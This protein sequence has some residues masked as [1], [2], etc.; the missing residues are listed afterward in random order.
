M[1]EKIR[2]GEYNENLK[3]FYGDAK[4]EAAK[5]RYIGAIESFSALYGI[6]DV[7]IVS[8][9]GRSEVLGNHTDHNRGCVLAAAVNLDLI[10]VVSKSLAGDAGSRI[11]IKSEGFE[12]DDIDTRDL[13]ARGSEKFASAAIIRGICGRF[14]ELGHRFGGFDAYTTSDV[15]PGSGLSSSAA[16]E[17]A[18]GF[19]LN[20]LYNGGQISGLEIAQIGQYAENAYFGKPCGLMD[21]T[22]CSVGGFVSIDFRESAAPAFEKLDFDLS[23]SGYSLC[24]VSTGGSH[25]NLN[26]EYAAMPSEMK[27]IAGHFGK[28]VLRE[29]EKPAFSANIGKLRELCGDRAVL[30]AMHYF[31]ENARV[32]AGAEAL[33][34]GDFEGFLQLVAS[35]GNSSYKY[36]QNVY[37]PKTPKE[38]GLSLALALS[39]EMLAGR[40]AAARVHG[41]GF[42][43]T[44]QAFVP[45]KYVGEY[46]KKIGG[47][48]GEGSC[49]ELSVRNEGAAVVM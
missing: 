6:R 1:A 21:Q 33:K 15:L 49:L 7:E 32:R 36:L 26:D 37:D 19:I 4:T 12:A 24:I 46:F 41:G 25:H 47:V 27:Q 38:Q 40:Q 31:A 17:V 10:A 11:R 8:V 42:A 29:V 3:R 16:F 20:H 44:I 9:P 45:K 22:A 34:E 35:S 28:E 30:R 39:E 13:A 2:N 48:F 14:A 18:V 5:R 23:K 43:G